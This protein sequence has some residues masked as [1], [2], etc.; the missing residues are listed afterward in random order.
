MKRMSITIPEEEY[1][2][3]KTI[4]KEHHRPVSNMLTCII[5]DYREDKRTWGETDPNLE[6]H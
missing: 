5:R 6:L 3:I 1:N 2:Y 4:S